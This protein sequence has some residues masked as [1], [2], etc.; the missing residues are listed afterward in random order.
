MTKPNYDVLLPILFVGLVF[1]VAAGGWW[2]Y[3]SGHA[4]QSMSPMVHSQT[5]APA[6]IDEASREELSRPR[7]S[8]L[9][10]H[11]VR[12]RPAIATSSRRI[13]LTEPDPTPAAGEPQRDTD[14]EI[15]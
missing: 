5:V 15:Y 14:A 12:R 7:N 1:P 9:V 13:A 10:A 4:D 6:R 2:R 3:F 8:V 11:P